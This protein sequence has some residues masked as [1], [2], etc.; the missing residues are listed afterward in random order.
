[1]SNTKAVASGIELKW[2]GLNKVAYVLSQW[3]S[4]LL[5]K[6]HLYQL[7]GLVVKTNKNSDRPGYFGVY[8]SSMDF[9][10]KVVGA[11]GNKSTEIFLLENNIWFGAGKNN[12]P[13]TKLN[14]YEVQH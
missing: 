13:Y 9:Y 3:P 4:F 8:N 12:P 7:Y 1:M 6:F 5:T 10:I 11:P 14:E 2:S